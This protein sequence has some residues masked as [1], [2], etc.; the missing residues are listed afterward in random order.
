MLRNTGG[1]KQYLDVYAKQN[2]VKF[3]LC[4]H[5]TVAYD[6]EEELRVY[7]ELYGKVYEHILAMR[8]TLQF[9]FTGTCSCDICKV[10]IAMNKRKIYLLSTLFA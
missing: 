8:K 7:T 9:S 5:L 2:V 6:L 1:F 4:K 10:Y 3:F